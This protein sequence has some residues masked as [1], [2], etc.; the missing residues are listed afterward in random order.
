MNILAIDTATESCSAA[1]IVDGF[2]FHRQQ[3]QPTGHSK[4]LL[5]M[6][7]DLLV[8]SDQKIDKLDAIAVDN[9][10]GSFTG[11][12]IGL[13]VAQG[14][15]YGW[16][17][18]V[19]AISSLEILAASVNAPTIFSAIDARMNQIYCALYQRI[20][21]KDG[22]VIL[23]EVHAPV[24]CDPGDIPYSLP[25]QVHVLGSG[26][27]TYEKLICNN[28]DTHFTASIDEFPQA[29]NLARI[30]IKKV[31]IE[32]TNPMQLS[33]Q[34]IRNNVVKKTPTINS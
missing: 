12:R 22:A 11:V 30:A 21:D 3:I 20:E 28:S 6:I 29:Q 31:D 27:D 9:G 23:S 2:E 16:N 8:E 10:P 25:S 15:A 33:A 32:K 7:D 24:V 26:W 18:P 19:V 5:K 1:V 13:G 14:L 17:L 4:L 34:Y